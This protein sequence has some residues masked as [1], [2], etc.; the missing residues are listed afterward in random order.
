MNSPT[1]SASVPVVD[2]S[3]PAAESPS[4]LKTSAAE[5]MRNLKASAAS[6]FSR[7]KEESARFAAEKKSAA[8]ERVG[9]YGSAIHDTARNLE[10]KDPNLAWLAHRTADRVE[11]IA[12][13]IRSRDL[14]EL[15]NDAE[16][17]ARR[18]PL[19]VFGGLFVAGLV[20]GNLIK[21]SGRHGS[22]LQGLGRYEDDWT[23]RPES[24]TAHVPSPAAP[25][26]GI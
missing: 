24:E 25:A 5:K 11:A 12:D 13:Y 1:S 10:E 17:L 4:D 14:L 22:D 23:D 20:V 3:S 21:A 26:E 2:P 6:S 19:A 9:G 7:A 16:D 15:R 18:H 8:A